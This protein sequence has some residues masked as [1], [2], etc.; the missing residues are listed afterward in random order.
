MIQR[1]YHMFKRHFFV[2]ASIFL[3]TLGVFGAEPYLPISNPCL[4]ANLSEML[5]QTQDYLE[6]K[7]LLQSGIQVNQI[8]RVLKARYLLVSAGANEAMGES[9]DAD[10]TAR[11]RDLQT[12]IDELGSRYYGVDVYKHRVQGRYAGLIENSFLVLLPPISNAEDLKKDLDFA[13]ELGAAFNQDSVIWSSHGHNLLIYT[14]GSKKGNLH[15]GNS[16]NVREEAPDDNYTAITLA[17]NS[18][19]YF[20]LDLDFSS[21]VNGFEDWLTMLHNAETARFGLFTF[22]SKQTPTIQSTNALNT[23]DSYVT[24]G[25]QIADGEKA[26]N[27]TLVITRGPGGYTDFARRLIR[28]KGYYGVNT[29]AQI[30]YIEAES[31]PNYDWKIGRDESLKRNH[32]LLLHLMNLKK[33]IVYAD[34]NVRTEYINN[35]SE[36]ARAKGQIDIVREAQKRGYHIIVV[37]VGDLQIDPGYLAFMRRHIQTFKDNADK[38]NGWNAIALRFNGDERFFDVQQ[39][40]AFTFEQKYLR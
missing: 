33:N 31:Y 7:K 25:R 11:D 21:T 15:Y 37:R 23:V 6:I 30:N 17:D 5:V 20:T 29:D 3:S 27:P 14:T 4:P 2:F 9:R 22:L 13:K 26:K 8:E 28:E 32:Q 16:V 34:M 40:S 24:V 38:E 10:Y 19:R 35:N 39:M 12:K 1:G 36:E 18:T